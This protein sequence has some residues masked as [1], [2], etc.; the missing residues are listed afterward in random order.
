[1][2]MPVA[3]HQL[4]LS[5][6]LVSA[7]SPRWSA[8]GAFHILT[9]ASITRRS[10]TSLWQRIPAFSKQLLKPVPLLPLLASSPSPHLSFIFPTLRQKASSSGEQIMVLSLQTLTFQS[11]HLQFMVSAPFLHKAHSTKHICFKKGIVM[12]WKESIILGNKSLDPSLFRVSL[13]L[14]PL[15]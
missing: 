2:M 14:F 9:N 8:D 4:S 3:V 7:R 10:I 15:G 5:P 12:E 11:K 6:H 1:M 13:Q